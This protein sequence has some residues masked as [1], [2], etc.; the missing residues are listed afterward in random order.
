M[1]D[2][3]LGRGMIKVALKHV[4]M[5]NWDIERLNMVL[6][7][8]ASWSKHSQRTRPGLPSGPAAFCRPTLRSDPLTSAMV[9]ENTWSP[10]WV[11]VLVAGSELSLWKRGF[12]KIEFFWVG[13][14]AT[15]SYRIFNNL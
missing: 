1:G 14:S 12:K 13:D 3:F 11:G 4:G 15:V 5:M 10:G 8:S 2:D 7:A 9:R 6:K